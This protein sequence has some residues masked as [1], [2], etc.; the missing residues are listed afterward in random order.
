MPSRLKQLSLN[1]EYKNTITLYNGTTDL[2]LNN[3]TRGEYLITV[4][5]LGTAY[6]ESA[7]ASTTFKVK[8]LNGSI[9]VSCDNIKIGDNATVII[10]ADVDDLRGNAILSI[11]GYEYDIYLE[12]KTTNITLVNLTN[13]TYD[14]KVFYKGNDKYEP[15]NAS[16]SFN[17][18]KYSSQ[19]IVDIIP[20]EIHVVQVY[21]SAVV[22]DKIVHIY[23]TA[24]LFIVL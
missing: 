16:C 8:S 15:S 2:I 11:N 9:S 18:T 7:N 3:F 21:F 20:D 5:Y 13:G 23:F 12:N 6:F 19:L 24:Y 17:V 14:L 22:V 1:N 10:E 4:E